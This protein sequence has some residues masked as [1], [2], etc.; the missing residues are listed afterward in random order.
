MTSNA[1]MPVAVGESDRRFARARVLGDVLQRLEA[2]EVDR[3]LD[4]LWV[5]RDAVGLQGDR[6]RRLPGLRLERGRK[7]LVGEQRRVDAASEVAQVLEGVG[8]VGLQLG[9]H[10]LGRRR[11]TCGEGLGQVRLH[12]QCDELLLGAVVDISLQLPSLLILRLHQTLPRGAKLLDQADVEH[13]EAGL[14]C[15]VV[16]QLGFGGSQR[17]VRRLGQSDGAEQL[18]LMPDRRDARRRRKCGQ[19]VA[20]DRHGL[21]RRLAADRPRRRRTQQ[22]AGPQPDVGAPSGPLRKHASHAGQDLVQV[23]AADHPFRELGQDLVGRRAPPVDETVREAFRPLAHGVEGDGDHCGGRDGQKRV[24][25]RTD[26]GTEPD[27]HREVHDGEEGG[28]RSVQD[29]LADD[30]VEVVQAVL[31]DRNGDRREEEHERQALDDQPHRRRGGERR[32]EQHDEDRRTGCEPLQ[33]QALLS[34]RAPEPHDHRRYGAQRGPPTESTSR[35]TH[36]GLPPEEAGRTG[37]PSSSLRT[38]RRTR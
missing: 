11:I 2:A 21:W 7:T 14:R 1:S 15:H 4:L 29:R 9:E 32:D 37:R 31:Q 6:D 30:E 18:A 35:S 28:K 19:L 13:H 36:N 8:R 22:V 5:A 24:V 25:R 17:I 27:H 20:V 34:D 26:R 38:P 10:R 23:V 16:D 12:R 3:G 33:L